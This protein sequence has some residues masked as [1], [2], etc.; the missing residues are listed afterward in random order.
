MYFTIV[1][2]IRTFV[3]F[4]SISHFYIIYRSLVFF[5]QAYL[6]TELTNDVLSR[7]HIHELLSAEPA[8]ATADSSLRSILID[9][10]PDFL[11]HTG[12]RATQPFLLTP[13]GVEKSVQRGDTW[14]VRGDPHVVSVSSG[15]FYSIPNNSSVG[16][17][18]WSSEIYSDSPR[19]IDWHLIQQLKQGFRHV[20]GEPFAFECHLPREFAARAQESLRSLCNVDRLK[21][22]GFNIIIKEKMVA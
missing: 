12:I 9:D 22:E 18:M 17:Y 16:S 21:R 14:L 6:C 15:S 2:N 4:G 5:F 20:N 11:P 1:S 10:R 19:E 7:P 13:R 3:L 8:N